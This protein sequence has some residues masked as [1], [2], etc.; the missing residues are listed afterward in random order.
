MRVFALPGVL[1][2]PEGCRGPWP[3]DTKKPAGLA[4][5]CDSLAY[6][7]LSVA[8]PILTCC[9]FLSLSRYRNPP[10]RNE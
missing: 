1:G 2:L 6:C 9:G 4:G 7:I 8:K 5:F 3:R 10:C